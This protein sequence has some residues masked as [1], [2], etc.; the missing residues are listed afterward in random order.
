ML[1]ATSLDKSIDCSPALAKKD[2]ILQSERLE[3]LVTYHEWVTPE[4]V[5]PSDPPTFMEYVETLSNPVRRLFHSIQFAPGGERVLCECLL[6]N[7]ILKIGTDGS[8]CKEK[9]TASFGWILISMKQKLVEG[10]GP[11]DGVPEFLSSTRVELYGIA[12]PNKFLHHFL[13]FHKIASMSKVIKCVNNRAAISRI[14]KTHW[15]GSKWHQYSNDVDI[16]MVIVDRMKT[17]ML[18]HC[19]RWVKAHQ[20][21]K[22]PYEALEIWG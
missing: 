4:R 12:A 22:R 18:R 13:E 3:G 10:T 5:V 16:M 19:L 21:D 1:Y 7:K 2:W 15:K 8:L 9:Q 14:N 6:N 11:V 20:D 17:S